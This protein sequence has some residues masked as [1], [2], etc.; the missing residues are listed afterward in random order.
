[1]NRS[2]S[3]L[4]VAATATACLAEPDPAAL[5]A[6]ATTLIE[7][8]E[9]PPRA[10]AADSIDRTLREAVVRI[11]NTGCSGVSTGSGF[12]LAPDVVA[13]NRHVLD[14]AAWLELSTWDGRTFNAEVAGAAYDA[15]LAI[16]LLE[17]PVPGV[18]ILP[19]ASADAGDEVIAVGFPAGGPYELRS[20]RVINAVD[21]TMFGEES[22][23]VLRI[24]AE[25]E[26]GSSGGP[27][28]TPDGAVVGVVFAVEIAS[29]HGL[30]LNIDE[31]STRMNERQL[32]QLPFGCH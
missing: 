19:T 29:G 30:A 31:L 1:M 16:A 23:G 8:D 18:Q 10:L 22:A 32:F 21:G 5:N 15:D 27:L 17:R 12:F 3:L 25:V 7:A 14:G 13:T 20:G 11:R 26:P 9:R 2:L 28:V 24:S 6:A 4:L